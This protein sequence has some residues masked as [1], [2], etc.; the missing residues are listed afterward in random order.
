MDFD[1]PYSVFSRCVQEDVY[2]KFYFCKVVKEGAALKLNRDDFPPL[3]GGV[4]FEMKRAGCV[5][6]EDLKSRR[7]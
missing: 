5:V 2:Q 3:R 1:D 6:K 7:N 4:P